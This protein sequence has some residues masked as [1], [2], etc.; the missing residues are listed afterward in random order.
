VTK[1]CDCPTTLP[2]ILLPDQPGEQ[3]QHIVIPAD[4]AMALRPISREE[5]NRITG[6]AYIAA[7]GL[8]GVG[9][10]HWGVTW[11]QYLRATHIPVPSRR[12]GKNVSDRAWWCPDSTSRAD[13]ADLDKLIASA[14]AL[15]SLAGMTRD[16]I[17]E[18]IMTL[19][20]TPGTNMHR[21]YDPETGLFQYVPPEGEPATMTKH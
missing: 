7:F 6:A 18:T 21:C 15:H 5:T 8:N 1:N 9:P 17:E 12:R 14:L 10:L 16:E 13:L 19:A 20:K 4:W 2:L 3:E 11:R